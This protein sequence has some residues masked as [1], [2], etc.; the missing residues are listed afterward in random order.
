MRCCAHSAH[1]N[2]RATCSAVCSGTGRRGSQFPVLAGPLMCSCNSEFGHG[3]NAQHLRQTAEQLLKQ[4]C[5]QLPGMCT[6]C[7]CLISFME[8]T[9]LAEACEHCG[10]S[11]LRLRAR[12]VIVNGIEFYRFIDQAQLCEAQPGKPLLQAWQ[13]LLAAVSAG[14][15]R[16]RRCRANTRHHPFAPA[17]HV[18][19]SCFCACCMI[20]W[21]ACCFTEGV[22]AALTVSPPTHLMINS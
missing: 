22:R 8:V 19:R 11:H 6:L 5:C 4:F 20:S 12:G 2:L 18:W 9:F 14:Q 13:G 16:R 17:S 1:W 15:D 3:I 7:C 10:Q 21:H